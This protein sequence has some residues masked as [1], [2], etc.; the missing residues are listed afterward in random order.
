MQL[1][2]IE[3]YEKHKSEVD[4]LQNDGAMSLLLRLGRNLPVSNASRTLEYPSIIL[5]QKVGF[6]TIEGQTI[7]LSEPGE[8]ISFFS[9]G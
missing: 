1:S 3:K 6:I 7:S 4:I 8:G 9:F 5:L 2:V